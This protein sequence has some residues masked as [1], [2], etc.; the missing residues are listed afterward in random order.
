MAPL[1]SAKSEIVPRAAPPPTSFPPS[2]LLSFLPSSS[3]L[4]NWCMCCALAQ[5]SPQERWE[6]SLPQPRP[7]TKAAEPTAE[8][9]PEAQP[10]EQMEC[11]RQVL[12]QE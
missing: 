8:Q 3:C 10:A 11:P 12:D 6:P 1:E 4:R 5:S 2:L 7:R 9:G